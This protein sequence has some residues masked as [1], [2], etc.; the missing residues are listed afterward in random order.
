MNKSIRFFIAYVLLT[1]LSFSVA[2]TTAEAQSN[3]P[4]DT[5]GLE[6]TIRFKRGAISAVVRGQIK[7]G[8]VHRYY[9]GAAAGQ[10]MAVVLKTGSQTSFTV[11]AQSAGIL[12]GADGVRQAVVEL[13][14]SGDYLIEIGTDRTANYTLEVAIK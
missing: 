8:T 6:K 7:L 13:P 9:V 4:Q 14:E 2:L 5:V 12:E 11:S 10:Q 3:R 1:A